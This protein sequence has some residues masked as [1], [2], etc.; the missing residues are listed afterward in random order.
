MM[1]IAA[2]SMVSALASESTAAESTKLLEGLLE[3]MEE[4]DKKIVELNEKVIFK[5][6]RLDANYRDD[7]STKDEELAA[8][9]KEIAA[10]RERDAERDAQI[11]TLRERLQARD[12]DDRLRRAL[13]SQAKTSTGEGGDAEREHQQHRRASSAAPPENKV[14]LRADGNT[15]MVE[16]NLN[17]KGKI[18]GDVYSLPTSNPTESQ[19]PTQEPTL[20]PTLR[21]TPEPTPEPTPY[22]TSWSEVCINKIN[23]LARPVEAF[24]RPSLLIVEPLSQ[25][26]C[27]HAAHP[28]LLARPS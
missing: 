7:L 24:P 26:A 20:K 10:L 2:L 3:R 17:V 11:A 16:G 28:S 13:Q 12:D 19:A 25:S 22:S 23:A 8:Q 27:S 15:L 1:L 21:P 5:I 18:F 4:Q 9:A 14:T 6:A